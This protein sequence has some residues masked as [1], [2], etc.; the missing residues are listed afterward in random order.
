[1]GVNSKKARETRIDLRRIMH[2]AAAS[3]RPHF[4]NFIGDMPSAP[5]TH[6]YVV[7]DYVTTSLDKDVVERNP[8]HSD[9]DVG[10]PSEPDEMAVD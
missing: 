2:A 5:T 3:K 8:V 4:Q 1:M 7:E 6:K 10:V 9:E